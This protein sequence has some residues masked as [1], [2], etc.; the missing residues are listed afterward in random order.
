MIT[1]WTGLRRLCGLV[2][3][4]ALPSTLGASNLPIPSRGESWSVLKT[5]HFLIISDARAGEVRDAARHLEAL[6]VAVGKVTGL[7]INPS[8]MSTVVLLSSRV[9][10][11]SYCEALRGGSCA[12]IGGLY[13]RGEF[14]DFL[15]ID[16]S[17]F[18]AARRTVSRELTHAIVEDSG[19]GVPVWLKEGVAEFYGDF[20]IVGSE[21]RAGSPNPAHL[22]EIRDHSTLP[23][24]TLLAVTEF[25]PE[26]TAP[27]LRRTFYAQSWLTAHCL[28]IGA[29]Q[30]KGQLARYL[31]A[32][33]AGQPIE[34]AFSASFG[35][36]TEAF[37]KELLAYSQSSTMPLLK[38]PLAEVGSEE[39]SQPVPIP[40]DELLSRL[41]ELFSYGRP[42]GPDA[43]MPLVDEGLAAAPESA[44]ALAMKGWLLSRKGQFDAATPVFER[45]VAAAPPLPLP[46]ALYG[47]HLLRRVE[48]PGAASG[49]LAADVVKARQLFEK[50]LALS[51][52]YV[53][54]L[55]GF[56]Q[57]TRGDAGADLT[58]A[59]SRLERAYILAPAR[60]DVAMLLA[61][62]LGN[63]G[64]YAR[65]GQ[66]IDRSVATNPDAAI[67]SRARELRISLQTSA[68]REMLKSGDTAGAA[69]AIERGLA[70]SPDPETREYLRRE[71]ARIREWAQ[72]KE[73]ADMANRGDQ[74]GALRSLETLLPTLTDPEAKSQAAALRD[75]L[76]AV[77]AAPTTTPSPT[78]QPSPTASGA[79]TSEVPTPPEGTSRYQEALEREA[80]WQRETERYN[81]AV[82]L[83][84]RHDFEGALR[85]VEELAKSATND[86]VKAAAVT[87]RNRLRARLGRS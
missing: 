54:A 86:E 64:Q 58:L 67:R 36:S 52:D 59:I 60:S 31:D 24:A 32:L 45:A 27:N 5:P 68:T 8:F 30:R 62:F 57:T 4:A 50:A 69:R 56:A 6:T 71:L 34:S 39:P 41:G 75:R 25:S 19:P 66:I 51:P 78:A 23:M 87:F 2:V 65:A 55:I 13:Q 43:A 77:P 33:A 18:D 16:G 70:E 48:G 53:P 79:Q 49:S 47:A 37:T 63:A 26:Y 61:E 11:R 22:A 42:D 84:N 73:L 46:Y 35:C 83:N 7:T 9:T 82:A 44:S 85:I 81:Q 28:L 72:V 14:G 10:F 40:R 74:A 21:I 15:L 1:N 3:L 76:R 12:D 38:L 17:D 80:L 29:P 20:S